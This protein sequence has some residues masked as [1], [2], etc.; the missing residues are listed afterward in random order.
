MTVRSLLSSFS[1]L[2]LFLSLSFVF[3]FCFSSLIFEKF[4]PRFFLFRARVRFLQ[5][6]YPNLNLVLGRGS[7]VFLFEHFAQSVEDGVQLL[8]LDV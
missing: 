2:L 6:R 3:A 7:L 8:V 5:L 4:S 1:F